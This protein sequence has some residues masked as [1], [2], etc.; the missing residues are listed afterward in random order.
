M[1]RKK[2]QNVLAGKRYN[3]VFTIFEP[4][5]IEREQQGHLRAVGH[6]FLALHS[7]H[8]I[9]LANCHSFLLFL[10]TRGEREGILTVL[11]NGL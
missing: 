5:T 11:H 10:E 7:P 1:L 8:P 6:A 3:A 4:S 9:P 2:K